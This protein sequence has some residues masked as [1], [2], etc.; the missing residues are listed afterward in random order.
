MDASSPHAQALRA[1]V[2]GWGHPSLGADTPRVTRLGL[3]PGAQSLGIP[4]AR[5]D[6]GRVSSRGTWERREGSQTGLLH[7]FKWHLGVGEPGGAQVSLLHPAGSHLPESALLPPLGSQLQGHRC[8][9]KYGRI[10]RQNSQ[11]LL[12]TE[13]QLFSELQEGTVFF[14]KQT[15]RYTALRQFPLSTP[16]QIL[17]RV[18]GWEEPSPAHPRGSNQALHSKQKRLQTSGV[19]P[20]LPRVL[21]VNDI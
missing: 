5:N 8:D 11:K 13:P 17:S 4:L 6:H 20:F 18:V 14:L 21:H 16:A 9:L 15:N 3:W 7:L 1:H 12:L 2:M 19:T 10:Y